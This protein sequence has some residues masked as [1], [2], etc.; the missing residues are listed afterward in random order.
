MPWWTWILLA[1]GLVAALLWR[2]C[3]ELH[4]AYNGECIKARV[5][6]RLLFALI[7]LGAVL[8]ARR[9]AGRYEARIRILRFERVYS[10]EQI[11]RAMRSRKPANPAAKALTTAFFAGA[12]L[13][14]IR[15]RVTL[16]T[17]DAAATA[18][19]CGA[20][21]ALFHAVIMGCIQHKDQKKCAVEITPEFSSAILRVEL[22]G[23]ALLHSAQIIFHVI[24]QMR[25]VRPK[26][27]KVGK[28]FA[29]S[30]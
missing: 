9:S 10:A 4:I 23:I 3:V 24:K 7:P 20:A 15:A 19:L 18:L 2:P 11:I 26:H 29:T 28:K 14:R 5:T 17:G 27:R 22:E 25:I 8:T 1:V 30:H 21:K 6:I 13:K 12:R 16:G